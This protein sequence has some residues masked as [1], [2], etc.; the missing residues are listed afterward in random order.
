[1]IGVVIILLL[2][3]ATFSG[4]TIGMFSLSLGDLERRI[5]EG[6]KQAKKIYEIRKNGNLLLCTLLLGNTIVNSTIAV[7]ISGLATGI[8]VATFSSVSIFLFA[9]VM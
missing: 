6:N 8:W 2:V 1:M 7:L 3:S 4:L 5:K 9:E